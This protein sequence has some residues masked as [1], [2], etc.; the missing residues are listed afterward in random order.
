[1]LQERGLVD[2]AES[3]IEFV[4]AFFVEK[5]DKRL[6]MVIDCRRANAWFAEPAGVS[7][8]TG[9]AL[10]KL[11]L[12]LNDELHIQGADLSDAFYHMGLP[13]ELRGYFS[14]RPVRASAVGLKLL[15]GKPLGRGALVTPRLA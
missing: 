8:C 3:G 10:S 7:L 14:F 9:D 12:G 1:M 4:E 2:F 5:K 13:E 6:R 11:E 15:G